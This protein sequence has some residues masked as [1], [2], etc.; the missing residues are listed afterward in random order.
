MIQISKLKNGMRLI[1]D[2]DAGAQTVSIGVWV[3]V[4]ARYETAENNGISHVLEHMAFKGTKTRSAA[5]IS[6]AIEDVG[7]IM[8]A[9][10]GRD[11]TAYYVKVLKE[12]VA[13]GI[14]LIADILQHSVMD[15]PNWPKNKA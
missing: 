1:T 6:S 15:A 10:T 5:Q 2:S 13:L 11:V 8:N 9:Y 4:G 7:G 12:D 14:D 3:G